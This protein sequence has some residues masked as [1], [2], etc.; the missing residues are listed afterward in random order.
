MERW[1]FYHYA[2]S[3]V[4]YY[5]SLMCYQ[6]Q[7]ESNPGPQDEKASVLPLCYFYCLILWWNDMFSPMSS[8]S[9]YKQEQLDLNPVFYHCATSVGWYY[10]EICFSQY[11]LSPGTSSDSW[12]Q[13]LDLE[14]KRQVFCHCATA[15]GQGHWKALWNTGN[16][17]TN[18]KI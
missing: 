15:L 17:K 9:W 5:L 16:W 8:L 4:W 6:R 18:R 7:L 13:T 14:M 1:V 10:D 11:Y 12:N 3:T 2:T